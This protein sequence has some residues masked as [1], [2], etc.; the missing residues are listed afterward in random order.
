[1]SNEIAIGGFIDLQVN[2]YAGIGFTDPKT[3]VTEVLEV[4]NILADEGTA[5]FLATVITSPRQ[6]IEHCVEVISKAIDK[7]NK[8]RHILGIHL[9]GPFISPEY[10][11]RGIHPK[12][13]I[14]PPDLK[15]FQ[16]LQKIANNNIRVV[17]IAPEIDGALEF[18]QTV[19]SEVIVS[20]GHSNCSYKILNQAINAGLSLAT[21][22][23]NGCKQ[24]IDRHENPIVNIIGC[25]EIGLCFIPDGFH[26]PEAFIRMIINC[27]SIEKLY[28]ISDAVKFAGMPPNV[29]ELN[30]GTQ[31]SLAEDGKLTLLSDSNLL[32]GSST[33]MFK[34]MNNLAALNVLTESDLIRI[35]YF[36][37]LA[38]LNINPNEYSFRG[39]RLVFDSV[40]KQFIIAT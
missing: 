1:M 6:E 20:V 4:A 9:E 39:R 38:L 36:N 10:G 26:L 22:I 27:R 8:E 14:F 35:G 24:N 2:G 37:Q 16:R 7:Q 21:H 3:T 13:S 18:I 34:C 17:T 31:I 15:W 33:N 23:G 11:Y 32:A 25:S 19:S 28:V 5:G 40:T 12:N 29:Y 30:D